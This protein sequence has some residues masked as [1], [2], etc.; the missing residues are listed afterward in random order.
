MAAIPNSKTRGFRLINAALPGMSIV[1]SIQVD[2][3]ADVLYVGKPAYARSNSRVGLFK[4]V[5]DGYAERVSVQTGR[6]SVNLI[7]IS[8]GLEEGD[9]IILSDMSRWDT[10]SRVALR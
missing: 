9:Q 8:E 6:G 1:A 5:A 3:I 7:E 10:A 4:L 2:V